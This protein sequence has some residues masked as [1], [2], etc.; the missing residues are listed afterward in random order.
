MSL[1]VFTQAQVAA[2]SKSGD[3]WVVIRGKVYNGEWRPPGNSDD[4]D[5]DDAI[6]RK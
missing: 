6:K 3:A 5:D 2:H 1:P 4:D